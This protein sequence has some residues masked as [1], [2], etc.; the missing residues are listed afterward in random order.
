[1]KA[2]RVIG[3]IILI[4]VVI[5]LVGAL[6]MPKEYHIERSVTVEASAPKIYMEVVNFKNW[7]DWSPWHDSLMEYTYKGGF[8]EEGSMQQWEHPEMGGGSQTILE[9]DPPKFI[10]TELIFGPR[11]SATSTWSFE[12]VDEGTK[13]TWTLDGS[14]AY[15]IGRW[16]ATLFIVPMV[17]QS[18]ET[19]LNQLKQHVAGSKEDFGDI[20]IKK[21]TLESS[22]PMISMKD[23]T[24]MDKIQETIGRIYGKLGEYAAKKG[25]KPAEPPVVYWHSFEMDQYAVYEPAFIL[26]K[27]IE[28][29]SNI[30]SGM[31]YA[32]DVIMT[33][34]IGSYETSD[35]AWYALENYVETH[36]MEMTGSPW[37]QYITDPMSEPDTGKWITD[38]YFP[39]RMK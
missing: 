12:P 25:A 23:S 7:T 19:G 15:P 1:M 11:G 4:L 9:L 28:G 31:T 20:E 22:K 2:L 8:M 27:R 37:E 36:K 18:Y 30:T 5:V 35:R 3:I 17:E 10:K 32:G 24:S 38:I 21:T 16:I 29:N 39:V 34:H 13:V 26:N 33:R 14:Q 6:F